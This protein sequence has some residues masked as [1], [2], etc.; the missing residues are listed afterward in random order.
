MVLNFNPLQRDAHVGYAQVVEGTGIVRV[1]AASRLERF[2]CPL[3]VALAIPADTLRPVSGRW[4]IQVIAWIRV[5]VRVRIQVAAV[6][7]L[8]VIRILRT[9]S[10]RVMPLEWVSLAASSTTYIHVF[11]PDGREHRHRDDA[12]HQQQ[13]AAPL[14]RRHSQ[15]YGW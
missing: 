2:E 7:I 13:P 11:R 15:L 14:H 6:V 4:I 8:P 3:P 10:T 1:V 9:R 12:K 5:V